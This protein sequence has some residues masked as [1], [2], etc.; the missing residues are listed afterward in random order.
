VH[1]DATAIAVGIDGT[2]LHWD[3]SGW[4]TRGVPTSETLLSVWGTSPTEVFVTGT[5]GTLLKF[6]GANW[7]LVPTGT[8][9]N[10]RSV[11]GTAADD[12]VLVGSNG[13]ILYDDGDGLAAVLSPF[14]AGLNAVWAH[15]RAIFFVG[16]AGINAKLI[17]VR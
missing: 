2:V 14:A 1:D 8:T 10:L 3:G 13:E 15:P 5:T 17:R 6:D 11:H 9:Q 12:L 4:S 7:R 16:E